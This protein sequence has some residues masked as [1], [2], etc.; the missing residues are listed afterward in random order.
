MTP[1]EPPVV[2]L[3]PVD[4]TFRLFQPDQIFLVPPSVDDWLPQNHLAR[5]I[6]DLVDE[7]LDLSSFYADYTE[8][9]G[10]PPFDPRLMVRV[11]L[12]GYTTGVRSSRKLEEACWDKVAFRW[13]AGGE[14][15]AYRAI[16]KFRKRHLSA[17]GHLFVQALELCQAAGMVRLGQ[18]ALDG[19]KVRANASRR[20]A[21]SY[22][23]MTEKQKILAAEVSDLLAQAERIDKD[24]D[25]TF[26]RDNKGFGL[27]EELA[28]REG[29]LA[30]ITQAKAALEAEARER[31]AAQAAER[32]RAAGKDEDTM[33][34]RAAAA[35]DRAVPKPKAQRNFTDPDSRIMKTADGSFAQ[36]FNAQAVVDADHQVIIATGLDNCAADSHTFIPMMDQA[37]R[38]TGRSPRQALADAGYCSQ[39]NLEGAAKLTGQDGTEFLIAAGRLG[40]DEIVE[41]APLGPVSTGLTLKQRMARTLRTDTGKADY[42]RRKAIVEPVF[43]Q[44]ATLQGKHVLLRGLEHARSEWDLLATCH[45]LR[46]LHG[47]LGVTGLGGLRPAT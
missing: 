38:N 5:F 2:E 24:E 40:H 26:G 17:L 31:A 7:H 4:K 43:G 42:A 32:A 33:A 3:G 41:A 46:K 34:E 36:C 11:L 35:A 25:A 16:A 23:R 29:R 47:H 37:R 6:A 20:K 8:G 10:A 15:P 30:K 22:A 45:N 12:L 44:I 9:R 13:L 21:M 19:T 27:P 14:A 1:V 18:V 39:A 28:L